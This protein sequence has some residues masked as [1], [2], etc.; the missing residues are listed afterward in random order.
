MPQNENT[1]F[2]PQSIQ[3]LGGSEDSYVISGKYSWATNTGYSRELVSA[4]L[5]D[6]L[7][8]IVLH[9]VLSDGTQFAEGI[10]GSV[11]SVESQPGHVNLEAQPAS[12]QAPYLS[13]SSNIKL[14]STGD[15]ADGLAIRAY[16]MSPQE[17]LTSQWTKQDDYQ[18][19]CSASWVHRKD[20]GGIKIDHGG[21]LEINTTSSIPGLDLDVYIFR[22]N[23][24]SSW[25]CIKD[26]VVT[27]AIGASAEE[28]IKSISRRMGV[29]G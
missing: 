16:G 10:S 6:G 8:M 3:M 15:I 18:N 22:D 23:G 11:F 9:N 24:D 27:Y 5:N 29:I 17:S 19:I 25:N 7:G 4:P 2:G 26:K 1:F 28:Q 14:I 12:A 21:L 20:Q 13:S